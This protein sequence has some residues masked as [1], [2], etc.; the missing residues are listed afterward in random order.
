MKKQTLLRRLLDS[1]LVL[2]TAIILVLLREGVR[3]KAREWQLRRV[4]NSE[5]A[6]EEAED[7][8]NISIHPDQ[9]ACRC[10]RCASDSHNSQAVSL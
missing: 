1:R 7:I 8:G 6:R 10:Y 4:R 5:G 3:L 2:G 9:H